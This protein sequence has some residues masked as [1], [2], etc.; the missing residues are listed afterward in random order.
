MVDMGDLLPRDLSLS[1]SNSS[2]NSVDWLKSGETNCIPVQ[3]DAFSSTEH[4]PILA[5]VRISSFGGV[6]FSSGTL[7][8]G[9]LVSCLAASIRNPQLM[10]TSNSFKL[11]PT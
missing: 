4:R 8:V 5:T 7:Y 11:F 2:S 10:T 9:V 3:K 1:K 6:L